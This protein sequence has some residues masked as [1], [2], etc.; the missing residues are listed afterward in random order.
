MII[1]IVQFELRS[2]H[3]REVLV[4]NIPLSTRERP[5]VQFSIL[6]R[7]KMLARVW[8]PLPI[9]HAQS[10]YFLCFCTYAACGI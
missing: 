10:S 6:E 2:V 5:N 1:R 3:T 9:K 8:V 7:E 4:I